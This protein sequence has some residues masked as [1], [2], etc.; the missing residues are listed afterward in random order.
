MS[1]QRFL[2]V[3]CVTIVCLLGAT[4]CGSRAESRTGAGSQTGAAA[5]SPAPTTANTSNQ[6]QS[7][8][9][10][11][12]DK[13][14]LTAAEL[15]AQ[16]T[17][18]AEPG[19]GAPGQGSQAEPTS[20]AGQPQPQATVVYADSAY[21]FSVSYP[22]DFVSRPQPAEKLAQLTPK[23]VAS[24]SFLN[25]V[26]AS[27]DVADLEPADLEVRVYDVEKLASLDSWLTSNGLLPA[28]GSVA[29]KPFQTANVSGVQV[30]AST[31]I[32]PGC[33]YFVIVSGR[34]YQLTPATLAGEAMVKTFALVP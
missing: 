33:S 11:V 12:V 5:P 34:V 21:K 22:A 32:A 1:T 4:A 31:M 6:A 16:P 19:A 18:Q 24:F 23:P 15:A 26:S 13:T 2:I 8:G 30:C 17:G 10:A 9:G 20:Q 27:S 7:G 14:P 25:P 3:L 29:P 28:D